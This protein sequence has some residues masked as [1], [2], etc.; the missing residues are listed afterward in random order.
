MRNLH[1]IFQNADC[2]ISLCLKFTFEFIIAN[3]FNCYCIDIIFSN[4]NQFWGK[5]GEQFVPFDLIR[6]FENNGINLMLTNFLY[7]K[8]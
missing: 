3:Q 6:L 8:M 5:P 1:T 4:H 2:L 7:I